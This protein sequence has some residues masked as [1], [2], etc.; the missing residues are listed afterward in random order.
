MSAAHV[1][2]A[3]RVG[4]VMHFALDLYGGKCVRCR[5]GILS[6]VARRRDG[7]ETVRCSGAG[8]G[9][10]FPRVYRFNARGWGLGA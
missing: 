7:G 9:A 10:V 5:D 1:G 6:T 2:A 3:V 4:P 8:C